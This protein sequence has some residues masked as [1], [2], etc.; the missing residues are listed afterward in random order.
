VSK[1]KNIKYFRNTNIVLKT[2]FSERFFYYLS[3][4]VLKKHATKK[5][6]KST[7]IISPLSL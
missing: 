7:E 4:Y 5:L 6:K 2:G 3:T 1:I